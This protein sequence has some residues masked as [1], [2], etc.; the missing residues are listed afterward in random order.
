MRKERFGTC[1]HGAVEALTLRNASGVEAVILTL[2][3]IVQALRVPAAEGL[4]DV[5]L[6][7]DTVEGY[8]AGTNYFGAIIGRNGNRIAGSRF[9]LNGREIILNANNGPHNLHGGIEGFDRKLWTVEAAGEDFVCLSL[10]SPDG[11]EGFPGNARV[12]VTY[13]VTADNALRIDY[14]AV[15]DADTVLNLT[16][17]SYFNLC[18]GG[19]VLEHS[20]QIDA[21]RYTVNTPEI[22]PT[23]V[24]ADVTGTCMDLRRPRTLAD[25]VFDPSL[26][27]GYD[28]NF[29]LRGEGLRKVAVLQGGGL[30]MEMETTTPGLQIYCASF[31][32]PIRGKQTYEGRCFICLEAQAW[33]DAVHHPHFPTVVVPAGEH[34]RQTTI[35][36]FRTA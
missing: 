23:G 25:V 7:Y 8:L 22:L 6:G 2:G 20:L 35:Y 19:S 32:A 33:P 27:G 3:G 15:A 12:T 9:S 24:V 36:R 10:L 21:D 28:S 31:G 18:G 34:Y 14:D 30:T 11:E 29:C 4:R 1:P 13:T 17:H 26:P 16:N 5:V